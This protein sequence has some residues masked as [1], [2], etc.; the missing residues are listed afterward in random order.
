MAWSCIGT[1]ARRIVWVMAHFRGG[2]GGGG[3]LVAEG[4]AGACDPKQLTDG[5]RTTQRTAW[6]SALSSPPPCTCCRRQCHRL[7]PWPSSKRPH[8]VASH[9]IAQL[10]VATRQSPSTNP[11]N[12]LRGIR[13]ARARS[14][15]ATVGPTETRFAGDV[16]PQRTNKHTEADTTGN[17]EHDHWLWEITCTQHVPCPGQRPPGRAPPAR[18]TGPYPAARHRGRLSVRGAR[19]ARGAPSWL[20]GQHANGVPLEAA[21]Q[22]RIGGRHRAGC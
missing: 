12:R 15:T 19:G 17:S 2:C 10:L 9:R 22:N 18:C 11:P 14:T 4:D 16:W 13:H 1:S 7:Q 21:G 5:C 8:A 20:C 6:T 3:G